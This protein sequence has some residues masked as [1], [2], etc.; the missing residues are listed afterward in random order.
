MIV[1]RLSQIT[2]PLG[3]RTGAG[4]GTRGQCADSSYQRIFTPEA[5]SREQ[6]GAIAAHRLLM[7]ILNGN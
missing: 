1:Y 7:A 5:F 4:G 3:G 2:R 6:L